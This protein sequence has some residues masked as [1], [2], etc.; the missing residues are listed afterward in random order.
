METSIMIQ[1]HLQG[2]TLTEIMVAL[3]ISSIL[4]AGVLSIMSSSKRTYALQNELSELQDNARFVM[5]ELKHE[6][7]MAGYLGCSNQPPI[8]ASTSV[9]NYFRPFKAKDANEQSVNNRPL[10]DENGNSFP[11]TDALIVTSFSEPVKVVTSTLIKNKKKISGDTSGRGTIFPDP[12]DP[13]RNQIVISDCNDSTVYNVVATAPT[14][15]PPTISLKEKLE[16]NYLPPVDVFMVA[17][18][19]AYEVKNPAGEGFALF[20]CK[21]LNR[22][23][24]FCEGGETDE[25]WELLVEG[26]ENM[27]IRY[28]IDTG[29]DNV[30]N[31]YSQT[32]PIPSTDDK[33][34]SVRITLLIRTT[35]KRYDLEGATDK[36]FQLDPELTYN[37]KKTYNPHTANGTLESGYRHRM[38]TSTVSVRNSLNQ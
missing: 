25:K 18:S 24:L 33:V 28:G 15:T 7:R 19:V 26:V 32:P 11:S 23:E 37:G 12:T 22:N 36:D 1:K 27:Q 14:N 30:P 21:D 38:F 29:S 3:V 10:V 4:M 31:L 17:N 6:L 34:V 35:N 9:A 5:D 2:F 16:K 20:K 8:N 13:N